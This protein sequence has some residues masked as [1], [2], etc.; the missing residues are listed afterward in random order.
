[1]TD[2]L[3]ITPTTELKLSHESNGTICCTGYF[4]KFNPTTAIT[5]KYYDKLVLNHTSKILSR[6]LPLAIRRNCPSSKKT[7]RCSPYPLMSFS[8]IRGALCAECL[9]SG[10]TN[11]STYTKIAYIKQRRYAIWRGLTSV[12]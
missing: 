12:R 6:G 11:F 7:R 10:L 4:C 3:F 2:V 1:M 5:E 9:F 8:P